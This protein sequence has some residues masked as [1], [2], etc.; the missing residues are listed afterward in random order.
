MKELT[1][2]EI[3]YYLKQ[4]NRQKYIEDQIFLI[5]EEILKRDEKLE[6][7]RNE[8]LY[9]VQVENAPPD[10]IKV[11]NSNKSDLANIL[12][13]EIENEEK[14]KNDLITE[15]NKFRAEKSIIKRINCI[16]RG[17]DFED[18]HIIKVY[19]EDGNPLKVL[20]QEK[21]LDYKNMHNEKDRVVD[22][23]TYLFNLDRDDIWLAQTNIPLFLKEREYQKKQKEK[24]NRPMSKREKRYR[25]IGQQSFDIKDNH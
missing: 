1:R 12:I 16:K 25:M 21:H 15:Q 19:Y 3:I 5:Q 2:E 24:D 17:I 10:A 20:C 9:S 8:Y 13:R 6:K 11:N 4:P 14:Y 23:I 22:D 7:L 18:Y